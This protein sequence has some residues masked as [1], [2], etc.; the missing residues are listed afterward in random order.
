MVVREAMSL[1]AMLHKDMNNEVPE[2]VLNM[3]SDS[4]KVLVENLLRLSQAELSVL[5]LAST[6][7]VTEGKKTVV[8][9]VLTGPLPSVHIPDCNIKAT[10]GQH[11]LFHEP[12]PRAINGQGYL[13]VTTKSLWWQHE[14][15]PKVWTAEGLSTCSE[16]GYQWTSSWNHLRVQW[17]GQPLDLLRCIHEEVHL[18]NTLEASGYRSPTWRI[19]RALQVCS[20]AKVLV[21]ESMITAAPFFEG[22]GRPSKSYWGPQQGRRVTVGKLKSGGPAKVP[23]GAS[24]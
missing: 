23:Y 17:Q 16:N 18:Q 9:C 20:T 3:C 4:D 11:F 2:S 8:C 14:Q 24:E 21:G 19:L 1:H 22:A 13:R 5:N 6:T 7:I 12:I 10:V 15:F